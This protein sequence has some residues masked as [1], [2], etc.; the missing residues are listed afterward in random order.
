MPGE[1]LAAAE[2]TFDRSLL[3]VATSDI[4]VEKL[5]ERLAAAFSDGMSG[6]LAEIRLLRS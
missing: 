6:I 5:A 3:R 4:A 1:R 2:T